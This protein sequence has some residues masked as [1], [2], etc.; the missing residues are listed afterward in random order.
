MTLDTLGHG[1][2]LPNP[3]VSL[4][5]K[6]MCRKRHSRVPALISLSSTPLTVPIISASRR[7]AAPPLPQPAT[8]FGD[9]PAPC[10]R[11]L[12][13]LQPSVSNDVVG[14][15]RART[16]ENVR[17]AA[18]VQRGCPAYRLRGSSK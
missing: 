12:A 8:Q 16:V 5:V 10:S 15:D 4:S 11:E 17:R 2:R 13:L 18:R 9:V 1:V 7:S 14:W 6:G 3:R